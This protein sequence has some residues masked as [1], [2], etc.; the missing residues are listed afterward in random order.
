M[1]EEEYIS[2]LKQQSH[3]YEWCM[4]N[5]GGLTSSEAKLEAEKFYTYEPPSEEYRWLVFHDDAWH[6]AMLKIKGE[7]YWVAFPE[8][9]NAST[10]Y[11]QEWKK[12]EQENT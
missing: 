10:E 2:S 4:K 8:L 3:M 6:W 12:Y 9:A 7:Q 5:I 1:T 11:D